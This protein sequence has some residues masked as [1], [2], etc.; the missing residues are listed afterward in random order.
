M[1]RSNPSG[2]IVPIR[3]VSALNLREHWR[4]RADRVA[5]ERRAVAWGLKARGVPALPAVVTLT[6]IAP[7]RLDGDNLQ[8]GCKA[9]RDE[10]AA[11]LGVDDSDPRVE[12]RYEQSTESLARLPRYALRIDVRGV[13]G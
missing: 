4:K 9:A 2:I 7:R 11:W 8:G 13:D 1:R 5:G 12:W 3:I 6:R 10:V